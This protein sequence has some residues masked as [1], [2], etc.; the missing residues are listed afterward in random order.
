MK[1]ICTFLLV[2]F[3]SQVNSQSLAINT[4]GSTA[5]ISAL[6]DVKSTAKGML[7]P[8]MSSVERTAIAAPASGLLVYDVDSLAFSYYNGAVWTFL[9]ADADTS[10]G[11]SVNGNNNIT[12][13]NFFGT[14]T[15]SD[16]FFKRNNVNAG[17]IKSNTVAL[18]VESLRA[19]GN[20][21]NMAMGYQ[22]MYNTISGVNNI[23]LGKSNFYYGSSGD[24]NIA[25]GSD[26][27][28]YVTGSYNISIGNFNFTRNFYTGQ[29]F[30]NNIA[31]GSYAQNQQWHGFENIAMGTNALYNDTIGNNNIAIGYHTLEA[32][33]NG[34]GNIALGKNSLKNNTTAYSNVSIGSGALYQN[35]NKNN[36]VAIGDSALYN[37]GVGA[38]S[39]EAI[40]NTAIGSKALYSNTKGIKNT[41]NGYNALYSNI[42][43]I[44]NT[45]MGSEAGFS[46]N[47]SYGTY[48][49]YQAG[50][51]TN[52]VSNTYI[53][54]G[55]G[56]D[57]SVA[58]IQ[59]GGQNV[60]V[61]VRA[62][63][64]ITTGSNNTFLGT[65]ANASVASLSNA[66]AFGA[67]AF[68]SQSNSLILG[69][70]NGLNTATADTKVGIGVT[71]PTEKL[72]IG[73]GRL[74][75]RGFPGAGSAHGITWTNNAGTTDRAFI[76]M[77]TDD[78]IGIYNFG[79]GAWNVRVHNT[80]GEMGINKQPGTTLDDSRLQVKQRSA[81]ALRGIGIE[82]AI[83]TNRWDM[84][85]DNNAAPD[86]NFSYNGAIR[87]Y[88]QNATGN[89]IV[90]SDKRF[91]KDVIDFSGS[92][93]NIN[94]LKP[95]Q[96]HY[97]D[98]SPADRLSIGFM[99]QDVQKIFPDA[100]SEK[101]MDDGQKRLGINYQY[102]TVLAI[103]GIQEQQQIIEAQ[104]AKMAS[105]EA[106]LNT[107]ET[108]MAAIK[109]LLQSNATAKTGEK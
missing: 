73:N 12:A 3:G 104:Q 57:A 98:N 97:L 91:K 65:L 11:W 22:N 31:I 21:Y 56:T 60:C 67:N 52:G 93:A 92:L 96:Y 45:T 82:T 88:I 25:I 7:I 13:S 40:E 43:G 14:T 107:L 63:Q 54:W 48:I 66:A 71:N 30:M 86:Y 6:L 32:N 101:T 39:G 79:L 108:E 44:E 19:G 55:A 15:N 87:G 81:S 78:L 84:W 35:T 62:G 5:N 74:R 38:A 58:T 36:L 53:G 109:A 76:G 18:G 106:R 80:T 68:V 33:I 28:P 69:G 20:L 72:E 49:G 17:F 89:Y 1:A 51:N 85:V 99:A 50:R 24:Y 61:G 37:N 100:V 83:N 4:D 64:T 103:K 34:Y 27:I 105:Q 90:V 16:I 47:N 29:N 42:I 10:K 9:K 46:A 95:Y 41:A 26:N 59:T 94:Q 77:E 8:R 75:F 2:L 70:I 102:F 23:A